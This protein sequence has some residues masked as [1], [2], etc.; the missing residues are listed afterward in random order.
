MHL[1]LNSK[2]LLTF[3]LINTTERT[4]DKRT[5]IGFTFGANFV[6]TRNIP[7]KVSF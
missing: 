2:T 1:K 4:G 5:I 7:L 6:I 3:Q